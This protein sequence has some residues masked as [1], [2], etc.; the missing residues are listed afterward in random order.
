MLRCKYNMQQS[1][2][3]QVQ[4]MSFRNRYLNKLLNKKTNKK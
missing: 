1:V 4:E 2:T 3:V